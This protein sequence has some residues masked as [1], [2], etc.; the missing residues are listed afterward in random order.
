MSNFKV[1]CWIQ[2]STFLLETMMYPQNKFTNS[3]FK[4]FHKNHNLTS[5]MNGEL[6]TFGFCV[7]LDFFD[8]L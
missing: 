4:T 8:C 3:S 2:D 5:H 7:L 6:N 1:A